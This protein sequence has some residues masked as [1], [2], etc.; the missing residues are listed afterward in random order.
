M[1]GPGHCRG[2]IAAWPV[3]NLD[4]DLSA[5]DPYGVQRLQ[6]L[7]SVI[8]EKLMMT[9]Q[10]KR[11]CLTSFRIILTTV[12]QPHKLS[13]SV[14]KFLFSADSMRRMQSRILVI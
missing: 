5:A 4:R 14:L 13:L 11:A 12:Y 2:H 7:L 1:S 3:N 8:T 6:M 9:L 10:H